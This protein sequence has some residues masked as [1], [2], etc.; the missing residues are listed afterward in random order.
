MKRRFEQA[1]GRPDR[2]YRVL[3][4]DAGAP[5]PGRDSA[6][7]DN[8]APTRWSIEARILARE[9]DQKIA[10]SMGI[11]ASVI[12]AYEAVFFDVRERLDDPRLT[13]LTW[14]CQR[15][16][17]VAFPKRQYDLLGS[18]SA[19]TLGLMHSRL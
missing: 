14:L 8:R 7:V 17:L 10:G 2:L 19:I 1:G 9:D 3:E 12:E 4:Q 6:V 16:L 5:C 15:R 11:D 18:R 13:S